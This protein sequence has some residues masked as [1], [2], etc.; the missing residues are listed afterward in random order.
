[1]SNSDHVDNPDD[2]GHGD[3][4]RQDRVKDIT[5]LL[6]QSPAALEALGRGLLPTLSPLVEQPKPGE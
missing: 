3:D 2:E 1:M 6:F 5:D 4:S